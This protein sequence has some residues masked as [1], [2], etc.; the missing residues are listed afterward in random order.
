[1]RSDLFIIQPLI[2]CEYYRKI[3]WLSIDLPTNPI[4]P[5][6]FTPYYILIYKNGEIEIEVG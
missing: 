5:M 4:H 2:D 1:M 6:K 3:C